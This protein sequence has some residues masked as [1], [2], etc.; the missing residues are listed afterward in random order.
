MVEEFTGRGLTKDGWISIQLHPYHHIPEGYQYICQNF[1]MDTGVA[2]YRA[3]GYGCLL[4]GWAW[5][6]GYN[7][8][9]VG[10]DWHDLNNWYI[11]EPQSGKIFCAGN[12]GL[13]SMYHTLSIRFPDTSCK[14]VL[15]PI[16]AGGYSPG[17]QHSWLRVDYEQK[18]VTYGDTHGLGCTGGFAYNEEPIPTKFDR[19]FMI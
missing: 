14:F 8:F 18:L 10:G 2:A 3:L 16:D 13:P 9:W 17:V 19:A 7:I 12:T 15:P 4:L 5:T 6:H 11:L 1:A